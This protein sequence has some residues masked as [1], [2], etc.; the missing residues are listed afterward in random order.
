MKMM[1]Y[2][3]YGYLINT[4][5]PVIIGNLIQVCFSFSVV[6]ISVLKYAC[7]GRG[8][9]HL[10]TIS[11]NSI[12]LTTA[13]FL[14]F[15]DGFIKV[16]IHIWGL[17]TGYTQADTLTETSLTVPI[18]TEILNAMVPL[19]RVGRLQLMPLTLRPGEEQKPP[20]SKVNFNKTISRRSRIL[21]FNFDC[22]N[23]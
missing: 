19:P 1:P 12:S 17:R 18:Y 20:F 21:S 6:H 23:I 2:N 10:A 5:Y 7:G 11:F 16:L 14:I 13:F 15:T 22:Q 8:S 4:K 3:Y 9:T